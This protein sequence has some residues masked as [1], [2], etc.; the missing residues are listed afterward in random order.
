MPTVST[1]ALSDFLT[2]LD[3]NALKEQIGTFLVKVLSG[4]KNVEMSSLSAE[5]KQAVEKCLKDRFG[6][7]DEE[8][9]ALPNFHSA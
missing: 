8:L 4:G 1:Q 5:D 2:A 9:A 7:T 6:L 3:E